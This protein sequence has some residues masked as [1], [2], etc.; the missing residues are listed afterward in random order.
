MVDDFNWTFKCVLIIIIVSQKSHELICRKLLKC[1]YFF[2]YF[3]I[4]AHLKL[5]YALMKVIC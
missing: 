5:A 1:D 2:M 3:Q 4:V